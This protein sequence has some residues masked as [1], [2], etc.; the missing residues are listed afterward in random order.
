MFPKTKRKLPWRPERAIRRRILLKPVRVPVRVQA[1]YAF[2]AV[3][4]TPAVRESM[5][6]RVPVPSTCGRR[7]FSESVDGLHRTGAVEFDG[8]LVSK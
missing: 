1:T 6:R 8:M 2:T 7:I 5:R 3:S 4:E